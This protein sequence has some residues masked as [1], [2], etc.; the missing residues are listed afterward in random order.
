MARFSSL[1]SVEPDPVTGENIE[2]TTVVTKKEV[3]VS[4]SETDQS[5]NNDDAPQQ[6]TESKDQEQTTP[7]TGDLS[8]Y[9]SCHFMIYSNCTNM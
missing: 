6:N 7:Q 3:I 1:V 2:T 8:F 5:S 4:V 9:H